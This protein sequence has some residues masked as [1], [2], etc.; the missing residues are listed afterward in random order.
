MPTKKIKQYLLHVFLFAITLVGVTLAGAEWRL[1]KSVFGSL[2]G[3][4]YTWADFAS[5]LAFSLPF[6]AFLTVHEFGHYLTARKYKVDSS[7]PYFI[8]FW[9]GFLTP[10]VGQL[11]PSIGTMGAVIRIKQ[12]IHSKIQHFDIGIAGPLAGFAVCLG[13]LFYGFTHLPP[14]EYIF[15]IHPEYAQ[16]G[17]E[18]AQHV[19]QTEELPPGSTMML[20][21]NLL[22]RFFENFV[23]TEPARVPN[24]YEIIHYPWLFAGFLG[25]FFTAV[26]LLPIGQL[27]GGHILYG[28]VGG[29]WHT[30]IAIGAFIL[31]VGYAGL[32]LPKPEPNEDIIRSVFRLIFYGLFLVFIFGK[33]PFRRSQI[34]SLA[35]AVMCCQLLIGYFLPEIN[36]YVGWMLF[37]IMLGRFIDV[38]HPKVLIEE[39]LTTGRK[40]LGWLALVI[41][42]LCFSPEPFV[43]N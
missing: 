32:E 16:Y 5:G 14:A 30:R 42:V 34:I 21:R 10:L 17:P 19:Y 13:I 38:R 7:L 29:K 3:D 4:T 11:V 33:L 6:L 35:L 18:Y 24:P 23:A 9:L 12:R 40:I 39:E 31:L 8:P 2:W 20:G 25:L 36:G 22:Y 28:L 26:N 41:F 37:G 15:E 1:S 27:D 43:F